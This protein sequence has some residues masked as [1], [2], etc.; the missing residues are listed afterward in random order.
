M[1]KLIIIGAGGHGKVCADIA[2]IIGYNVYFLDDNQ[3]ANL[4]IIGNISEYTKYLDC[5]FFVAIGNNTIRRKIFTEI[6]ENNGNIISLIHPQSVLSASVTIGK[7]SVVM[8]GVV[9]NSCTEVGIGAIINTCSSVDHDCTIGNF[10]HISVGAHIAGTVSVASEV[11]VG[12][13][14]TIIN[15]VSICSNCTIGAGAVVVGDITDS[16]TYIGLPAKKKM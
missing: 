11:F 5:D 9:I 13:G 4:N 7:G 15:N 12:A 3:K 1:K 2:K 10:S 8:P 16:G 6:F 14:A